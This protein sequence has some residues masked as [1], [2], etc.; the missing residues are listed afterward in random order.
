MYAEIIFDPDA[1][2]GFKGMFSSSP[3]YPADYFEGYIATDPELNYKHMRK[4]PDELQ[5]A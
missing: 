3:D 2:T 4:H 1:K 5:L